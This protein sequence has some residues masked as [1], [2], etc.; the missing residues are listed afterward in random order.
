MA[1]PCS[2]CGHYIFVRGFFYLLLSIFSFLPRLISSVA[3]WMSTILLHMVWPCEFRI[4][5]CVPLIGTPHT[6]KIIIT[7]IILRYDREYL[8]EKLIK[9]V[10]SVLCS[11]EIRKLETEKIREKLKT[12]I[13]FLRR[14][15]RR[16]NR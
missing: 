10:A 4:Q 7:L 5:F 13:D 2:S 3:D 6:F 1:A 11:T 16:D 15:G 14:Y 12:K 9:L 8:A